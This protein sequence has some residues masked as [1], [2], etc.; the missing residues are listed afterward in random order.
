MKN[1]LMVLSIPLL[2][3]CVLI[4]MGSQHG[5]GEKNTDKTQLR[6]L[7]IGAHPDDAEAAGGL[8]A[9]YVAHGD[10]VLLVSVTNGDKGHQTMGEIELANRRRIEAAGAGKVIG[11]EYLVMNNHDGELVPSLENRLEII[12]LIRRFQPD[13]IFTHPPND[14]HPDHRYTSILVQDASYMVMVPHVAPDVPALTFNPVVFY[15][16]KGGDQDP[17]VVIGIDETID[18]KIEMWH[19]HKSQIYEWL[20]WIGHYQDQVPE[21]EEARRQFLKETRSKG[22]LQTANRFRDI[23]IKIYGNEKG[24]EIRYAEAYLHSGFGGTYEEDQLYEYFPF[25]E[26]YHNE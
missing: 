7:V 9:L 24:K 2:T 5:T 22:P 4:C 6:V 12:R 26:I 15:M 25:L 16:Y 18:K 8:A 11:S 21:G 10:S 13:I 20:P 14:Y 19:Q 3:L 1:R 17:D 23:L